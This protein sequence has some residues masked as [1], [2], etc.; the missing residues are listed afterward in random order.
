MISSRVYLAYQPIVDSAKVGSA[1]VATG[2]PAR[3]STMSYGT[4]RPVIVSVALMTSR[5]EDP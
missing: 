4:A 3:R 2:S 5:T 1:K